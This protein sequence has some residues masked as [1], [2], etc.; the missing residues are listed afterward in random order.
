MQS[1][2]LRYGLGA[3]L[4][5]LLIAGSFSSGVLF[6]WIVP[7]RA[8]T[9]IA[10]PV[11]DWV[12][13]TGQAPQNGSTQTPVPANK[14]GTP[15]NMQD[16]FVPFWQSWNIVHD[17][18]V[19]Q[20]VDDQT[21][22]QGAIRGMV[23]ALG[24][25]HSSYND[26]VQ[27]AQM[28]KSLQGDYEGIGAYV[29]ITGQY[30]KITAPFP[31]SPAEKAGLKPNDLIIAVDGVDM[32]GVDGNL[33]LQKVLGPAGTNVVLTI[34][35]S[36]VDKPFDVTVTRAKVSAPSITSKML[37]GNIG[38]ISIGTFGEKT[39]DELTKAL[40]TLMPQKPVGLIIDLRN[41]GGGYLQT[42]IEV[43]SQFI[44]SGDLMFEQFGDGNRKTY[45]ALG[46]GLA[47]DVPLVVLVNKGTASASEITA[48]A[49]QDYGRGKLV[50]ETT[51]GKGS[52]QSVNPITDARGADAGTV[53]VTIAHWL[54]P[55]ERLIQGK[56]LT[57]DV[58]I[59]LTDA[60]IAANK[61]PQLDK[62]IEV[63]KSMVAK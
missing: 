35:R 57:P 21:L 29:D 34:S 16:L 8:Q 53:R 42:A 31:G 23:Q 60:D 32:T 48:G 7:V 26:P 11:S 38:Y 56:G 17:Q 28:S 20:P 39:T 6:G 43:L 36:G 18:Y 2:T 14:S 15:A 30:L 58:E 50:G 19:N 22:M 59:T 37:D 45:T 9:A 52:V 41:N 33:V 25:P 44:K 5:V 40:Q 47:T 13:P 3:L 10:A 54:T 24:D 49:I 4:A 1:K 46:H 62:A 55:K 63:M 51:Y 61:D 27:T 12:S